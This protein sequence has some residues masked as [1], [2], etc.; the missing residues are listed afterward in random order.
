MTLPWASFTFLGVVLIAASACDVRT[1]RV[2]VWLTA[3][4]IL[5][6]LVVAGLRGMPE[7]EQSAMGLV[8]GLIVP[9]PLV[10]LGGLGVADALLLGAVGAWAGWQL[11]LWTAWWAALVGAVLAFVLWRRGQRIFAY[12]PAIA[13]GFALAALA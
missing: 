3:A 4:G 9:L 5:G 12:V 6:G 2:P 7:L 11:A 8:V 13:I 1:R 10:L